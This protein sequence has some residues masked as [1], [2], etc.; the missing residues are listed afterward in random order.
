MIIKACLKISFILL[1]FIFT[2]TL[3]AKELVQQNH[4]VEVR[5]LLID[6]EKIDTVS[7]SFTANLSVVMRWRDQN[8]AH[9]GP[10]SI[11]VPLDDIWYPRI[12]ILNQQNIVSTLPPSAEI[13]PDGEVV[14]R[15]RFWGSFAQPLDLQS[16]P[17]DNQVLKI[18]LANV[19]FDGGIVRLSPSPNSGIYKKLTMPDWKITGWDF[20]A[21]DFLFEDESTS[22]EGMIFSLN[23]ERDSGF[24]KFKVILPLILI[25]MMS[26]LVFW[27]D[28][29]LA[30]SQ[31]SVSVTSMLTM[32]AY[33]FALAGMMPRLTFLTSLDYF[34]LASTLVVF[35]SMIEVVYTAHLS[36]NGQLEK[37]R[38]LDRRARWI[39]PLIY[40]AMTAETLYLR[41][42]V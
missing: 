1:V 28:P 4:D 10:A 5:V 26:W 11:S 16:F 2:A 36:T 31:I 23:V 38:M 7:Q 37:A 40:F 24:F 3:D 42:W 27:I 15:Q 41:I 14:Q 9:E 33:R 29:T 6:V 30:A 22:V 35:L 25:V 17:F 39:V 34:V 13:L 8:L 32:I 21:T 20:V 18:T 19:G 12:Q